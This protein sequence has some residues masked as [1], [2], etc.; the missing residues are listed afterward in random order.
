MER[1]IVMAKNEVGVIAD[2]TGALADAGINI[3]TINTESAGGAGV[4]IITTEDND[5]TLSAL[6]S[7]GFKAI[8]DDVLVVRLRDE[9]GALAKLAAKFKDAGVNIQSL[10]IVDRHEGHTM[11]AVSA[12]DRAKMETLVDRE[13]IV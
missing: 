9:P 6:T 3:L 11:V 10:H 1:I 7:A 12:D 13:S 8:M 5:A 4:I 2:L